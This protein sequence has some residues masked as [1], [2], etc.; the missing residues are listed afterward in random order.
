MFRHLLR[1]L[2]YLSI[3][4][5]QKWVV[6]W[7]YPMILAAISTGLL[8]WEPLK[9]TVF[10]QCPA[11]FARNFRVCPFFEQIALFSGLFV[12]HSSRIGHLQAYLGL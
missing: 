3:E 6:D 1:P 7:V 8:F 2:S 11:V 9:T 4:H 12:P 10:I 5:K